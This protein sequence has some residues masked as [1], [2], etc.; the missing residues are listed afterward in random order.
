MRMRSA[1]N[2]ELWSLCGKC[3][4]GLVFD[5]CC[6]LLFAGLIVLAADMKLA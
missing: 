5:A 6:L 3:G 4:G 1:I 2:A